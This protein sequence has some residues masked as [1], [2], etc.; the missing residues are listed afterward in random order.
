MFC[1]FFFPGSTGLIIPW[2]KNNKQVDTHDCTSLLVV[3]KAMSQLKLRVGKTTEE[4]N[5]F[6]QI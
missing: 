1:F 5:G 3:M 4:P 2:K 6:S